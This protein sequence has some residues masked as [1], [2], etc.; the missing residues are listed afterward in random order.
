VNSARL[1]RAESQLETFLAQSQQLAH[2]RLDNG[3]LAEKLAEADTEL[4][5]LRGGIS[6]KYEIPMII[7]D[8]YQINYLFVQRNWQGPSNG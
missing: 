1:G 2:T 8:I 6:G 5:A 3:K 4:E 7:S